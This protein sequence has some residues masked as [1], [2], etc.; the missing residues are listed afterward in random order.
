MY[1]LNEETLE[2]LTFGSS[3]A[4]NDYTSSFEANK[5]E[6]PTLAGSSRFGF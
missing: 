1:R 5:L 4:N 6:P 3:C 2:N